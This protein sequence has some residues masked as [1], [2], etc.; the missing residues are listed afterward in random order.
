M[1]KLGTTLLIFGSG[2]VFF[3]IIFAPTAIGASADPSALSIVGGTFSLGTL[4]VAAGLYLR[5]KVMAAQ[6]EILNAKLRPRK[7]GE[8][9]GMCEI[10]PALL[11]CTQHQA[12][13]CPACLASHDSSSCTYVDIS[14][15]AVGMAATGAWR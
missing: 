8:R 11:W 15:K 13:I 5:A 4:I 9:C 2:L 14:R 7:T 12:K 3:A 1:Q 10:A 6:N